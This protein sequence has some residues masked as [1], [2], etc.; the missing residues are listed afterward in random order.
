M[1][2]YLQL[3]DEPLEALTTDLTA[4]IKAAFPGEEIISLDNYSEEWLVKNVIALCQQEENIKMIIYRQGAADFK[5]LQ[6]IAIQIPQ[7][8]N[9][10]II[11]KGLTN[12]LIQK[13]KVFRNIRLEILNEH[14]DIVT[15]AK[16]YFKD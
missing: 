2:L 1:I 11:F 3:I 7:F 9:A 13:I 5:N 6:S 4:D 8:R 15:A 12:P 14:Q 16:I 10:V